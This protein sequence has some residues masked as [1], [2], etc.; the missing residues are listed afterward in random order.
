MPRKASAAPAPRIATPESREPGFARGR[1]SDAR[2]PFDSERRAQAGGSQE[3]ERRRTG[4]GRNPRGAAVLRASPPIV[5]TSVEDRC[6]T[7]GRQRPPV[8]TRCRGLVFNV[9]YRQVYLYCNSAREFL[10]GSVIHARSAKP[11]S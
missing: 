7:G 1:V 8:V 10:A 6:Q 4:R 5:P 2:I 3:S 11:A 9:G